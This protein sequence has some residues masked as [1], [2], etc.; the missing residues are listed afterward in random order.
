MAESLFPVFKQP[1]SVMSSGSGCGLYM[2]TPGRYHVNNVGVAA[3]T[4][5]N[6]GGAAATGI[7]G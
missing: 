1:L 6:V 3:A 4:V 2:S 7:N 5:D